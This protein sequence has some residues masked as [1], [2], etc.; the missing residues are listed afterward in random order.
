LST[1]TSALLPP[2]QS[3]AAAP[4][5]IGGGEDDAGGD[6][7]IGAAAAAVAAGRRSGAGGGSGY[8]V[9]PGVG[10]GIPTHAAL[11]AVLVPRR[12]SAVSLLSLSS[13]EEEACKALGTAVG[14]MGAASRVTAAGAA[15][16]GV[17]VEFSF[18]HAS[19]V[20]SLAGLPMEPLA[21]G[22]ALDLSAPDTPWTFRCG[23]PCDVM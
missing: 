21:L 11:S 13:D 9:Y 5:S 1:A 22:N 12:C 15:V 3:E 8:N 2:Q 10:G 6:S 18:S 20:T 17:D 7:V 23:S 14:D 4:S 19:R 16:G